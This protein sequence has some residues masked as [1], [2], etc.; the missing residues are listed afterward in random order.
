MPATKRR[1]I[2]LLPMTLRDEKHEDQTDPRRSAPPADQGTKDET[3][4]SD[5]P[6]FGMEI[7]E[8]WKRIDLLVE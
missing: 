8:N 7:D 4:P 6:G 2:P 1:D 5:A 3:V